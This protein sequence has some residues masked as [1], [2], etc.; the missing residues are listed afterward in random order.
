MMNTITAYLVRIYYMPNT[1]NIIEQFSRKLA[2]CLH[3][4]YMAPMSYLDIH[5]ARKERKAEAYRQKTGAYVELDCD[6]LWASF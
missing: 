5:P 2:A 4:N 3:K 1:S 6:P